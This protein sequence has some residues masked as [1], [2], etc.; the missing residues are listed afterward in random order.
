MQQWHPTKHGLQT[1][2]ELTLG[3]RKTVWWLCTACPCG[4]AHEWQA[5][6]SNRV[7][8]GRGCPVCAGKRSCACSSLAACRP[9]IAR[10]WDPAGNDGL[11]PEEVTVASNRQVQWVCTKHVPPYNWMTMIYHR[12]RQRNPTGCPACANQKGKPKQR[13]HN[14]ISKLQRALASC[15]LLLN[16]CGA[17]GGPRWRRV[18]C[19]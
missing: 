10:Q 12:T 9:D 15:H 16:L 2:E 18:A 1:P 8:L 11:T 19:R 3:S 7:L 5:R 6:V 4:H 13:K 17:Q 14:M